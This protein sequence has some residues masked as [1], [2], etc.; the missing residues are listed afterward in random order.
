MRYAAVCHCP[1]LTLSTQCL[2]GVWLDQDDSASLV[3]F[4]MC[5]FLIWI[6]VV[7]LPDYWFGLAALL[8]QANYTLYVTLHAGGPI[9]K[10][11]GMAPLQVFPALPSLTSTSALQTSE[12]NLLSIYHVTR[13]GQPSTSRNCPSTCWGDLSTII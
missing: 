3:P 8:G 5:P 9:G 10:V 12:Q 7:E 13:S 1:F 6:D 2:L 11:F 4:S